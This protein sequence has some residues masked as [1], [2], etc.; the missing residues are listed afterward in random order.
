MY[1]SQESRQLTN[2]RLIP[3]KAAVRYNTQYRC[4]EKLINLKHIIPSHADAVVQC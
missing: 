2:N 1:T 4:V 3:T